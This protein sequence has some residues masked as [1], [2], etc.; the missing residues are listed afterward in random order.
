MPQQEPDFQPLRS[1]TRLAVGGLL[2]V[3]EELT[4][5]MRHWEQEA[6]RQ[7]AEQRQ[8]TLPAADDDDAEASTPALPPA[9]PPAETPAE[10]VRFALVGLLFE[11]QERLSPSQRTPG[12]LDKLAASLLQTIDTNPALDPVRQQMN[13]L[14]ERGESEVNR[15]VARG[16]SEEMHSRQY[17][18][19]ALQR[20]FESSIHGVVQHAEVREMIHEHSAGLADELVEEV[21]EHAVSTDDYLERIVRKYLKRKPRE[22]LPEPP[23]EVRRRAMHLRLPEGHQQSS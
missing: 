9:L 8:Q 2:M 14:V 1:L 21:R 22:E 17:V 7:R 19:T 6:N 4:Y 20:S 13:R 11:T 3:Q 23:E 18:D 5:H 12:P 16:R 10:Q 15:W